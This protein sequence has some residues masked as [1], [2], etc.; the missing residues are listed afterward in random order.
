MRH[1]YGIGCFFVIFQDAIVHHIASR[2][3]N[4]LTQIENFTQLYFDIIDS[5]VGE[6][7][8]RFNERNSAIAKS[9]ASLWP[10]SNEDFLNTAQLSALAMLIKADVTST[11]AIS[12]CLVAAQFIKSHFDASVH[13]TVSDILQLLLPVKTA[14]PTV[15]SLYAAALTLGISTAT[16]EASF[17]TLTRILTPYRRSMTHSRK[18]NL[19]ILSFQDKYTQHVDLDKFICEFAKNSRRLQVS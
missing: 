3:L 16:C 10:S 19:V 1:T 11:A 7:K 9:V 6:L 5:C 15:Y 12:E 17:S 4:N 14:F 13:R 2:C 8:E 18:A